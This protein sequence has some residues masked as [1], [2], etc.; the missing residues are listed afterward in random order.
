MVLGDDWSASLILD[1]NDV[2]IA[3]PS[4]PD[5]EF[6]TGFTVTATLSEQMGDTTDSMA[7]WTMTE[8]DIAAIP[9]RTKVRLSVDGETWFLGGTRCLS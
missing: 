5:L 9:N 4:A 7:T 6:A 3:W 1:E 2:T 8:D